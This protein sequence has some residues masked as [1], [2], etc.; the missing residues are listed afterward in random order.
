MT[1][2]VHQ[3]GLLQ[4][5]HLQEQMVLTAQVYEK[6]CTQANTPSA[7]EQQLTLV[8]A[9]SLLLDNVELMVVTETV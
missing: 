4:L 8:M 1:L 6:V 5:Q 9:L 2:E 7:V 3:T